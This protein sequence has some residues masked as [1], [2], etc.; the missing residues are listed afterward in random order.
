MVAMNNDEI[1]KI[2]GELGDIKRELHQLN[3]FIAHIAG[4]FDSLVDSIEQN[5]V[6]NDH[7]SWKFMV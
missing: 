6:E 1:W 3:I 4:I 5:E 2:K 7:S